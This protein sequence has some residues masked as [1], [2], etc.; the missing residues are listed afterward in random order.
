MPALLIAI[1]AVVAAAQLVRFARTNPPVSGDLSAPADVEHILRRACYDCHS[2]ETRW[3]WYAGVAPTSWLVHHDIAE[4][5]QRLNFSDWADYASD[6]GT[7][8]QK[9]REIA[10]SASSGAMAPSYYLLLHH[11]ARLTDDERNRIAQWAQQEIDRQSARPDAPTEH[12]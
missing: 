6:P 3:P 7:V 2:N 9:L 10:Q 11:D 5:R 12:P 4:G 1:G 8:C